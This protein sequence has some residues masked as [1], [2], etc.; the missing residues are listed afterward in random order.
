M[1]RSLTLRIVAAILLSTLTLSVLATILVAVSFWRDIERQQT[2][3][4]DMY[5]AERAHRANHMFDEISQAHASAL[6]AVERRLDGLPA[7]RI[8]EEFDRLFPLQ[9]DGT[10]RS[11]D[12]LFDGYTDDHGNYHRGV[13]AFMSS[14]EPL[15][16]TRKRL[17]LAAYN[18]VDQGGE[19]LS[20]HIDNLYLFTPQ[21]E[22]VISAA[23]R[24]DRMMFYRRDATPDFDL[25]AFSFTDLVTAENNPD[26][27]FVCDELS[28]LAFIQNREALTT[29]CFTPL[30]RDGEH[31]AAF[32]TTVQ[33]RAHFFEA[34]TDTLPDGQNL[35]INQAGQLIA[36]RSLLDGEITQDVV[37]ALGTS[38]GIEMLHQ[39]IL[40]TA[41]DNGALVTPDGRWLLGFSRME[42]PNWFFVTL[43]D[44]QALRADA[45]R[46][47]AR[48]VMLA[49]V[50]VA[51]Q[52]LFL[53][54]YF[55]Q[56]IV[57]PLLQ[58]TRR[59][60]PAL[61]QAPA[62]EVNTHK[63][64]VRSDE[65]GTL[66]RT[67][68][69]QDLRNRELLNEL[70]DRVEART[71]QLE[72]ANQAKGEF[73]ANMSHE[74]RTP[75]NGIH[76]LAQAL[77]TEL[78]E[79]E[80]K[81]QAR[82]IQASGETLTL[83]LSDILDLSKIEAGKLEMSPTQA[84][85]PQLLRDI[86]ALFAA[87]AEGKGLSFTL[88]LDDT[89]PESGVVDAHRVR[90]C[91]SNLLS[92]AI[93]FTDTGSITTRAS[94]RPVE[95]GHLI[96]VRV[97]DSGIG[98]SDEV[99]DK[100]FA[101]FQQADASISTRFG[102]TG[103]G[104]VISRNLARLLDGDIRVRSAAGRGSTFTF[105]F[106]LTAE[107]A[108]AGP[109]TVAKTP[110]ELARDPHYASLHDR[111]ILLVEDN[112]INREVA[113]AFLKPLGAKVVEAFDGK[114]G[115][116]AARKEDVDL[117]L[118]D[119]RM[120]IMDGLEATRQIRAFEDD[121]AKLPIIALTANATE[122]DA[123]ACRKAGMNAF[124]AKPLNASDFFNAMLEALDTA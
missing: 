106:L 93:K 37:D 27:H 90:Q 108:S 30:R 3:S 89:L 18:V 50:G 62:T 75:L 45:I 101:P 88:E 77:E 19:M 47:T 15:D 48:I 112:L 35:F 44:R 63:L 97:E 73:I 118:M 6:R 95:A 119:M 58:L 11:I 49:V 80:H 34:M 84:R 72:K 78:K 103:L 70:E 56:H 21:N 43:L 99:M 74:L 46:E 41:E 33:L 36:H 54:W 91:L 79:P 16:T 29:G 53:L 115:V 59:F 20:G 117:I 100:L 94:A 98:M 116:E 39:A 122:E 82:M 105:E 92:N 12:A 52:A 114:Q 22:L 26:G 87:Q 31:V 13:A 86:H 69:D 109:D 102:G 5:I 2:Q 40:A 14:H 68:A 38:L 60:S 81:E 110:V 61:D 25:T 9:P 113:K 66:A 71:R 23:E 57:D 76:G 104:L 124:A 123:R 10:R 7:E 28:Q 32:G 8:D 64:A 85:L 17:L 120:P 1:K 24:E 55:R 83:M 67:L 111:S 4:L 121:K 42:G 107:E 65:I 96:S 51:L